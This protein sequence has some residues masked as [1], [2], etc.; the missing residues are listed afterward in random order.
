MVN[1]PRPYVNIKKN[2]ENL[3]WLSLVM[4]SN[5]EPILV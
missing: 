3:K 2:R 4:N 1:Y 5:V